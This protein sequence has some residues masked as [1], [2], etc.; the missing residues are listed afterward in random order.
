MLFWLDIPQSCPYL[1]CHCSL[2]DTLD[3][4]A[5]RLVCQEAR[6]F[7]SSTTQ[8]PARRRCSEA[9]IASFARKIVAISPPRSHHQIPTPSSGRALAT[10]HACSPATF[11]P[12]TPAILNSLQLSYI[13]HDTICEPEIITKSRRSSLEKH[14]FA[15]QTAHWYI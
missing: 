9:D 10:V 14:T 5:A 11:G 2:A 13:F 7:T 8:A 15:R 6:L 4:T 12:G 1:S 3:Q